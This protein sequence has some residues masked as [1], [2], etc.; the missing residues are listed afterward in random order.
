VQA[1]LDEL[2]NRLAELEATMEEVEEELADAEDVRAEAE[3]TV[4]AMTKDR[5]EAAAR[6]HRLRS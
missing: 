3:E 2:R 6:V 4:L 1:Q 5:D